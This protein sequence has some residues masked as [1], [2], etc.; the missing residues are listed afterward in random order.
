MLTLTKKYTFQELCEK[1]STFPV[2]TRFKNKGGFLIGVEFLKS[3]WHSYT[4]ALYWLE[5]GEPV[6]ITDH[7]SEDSFELVADYREISWQEALE[8]IKKA[9]DCVPAGDPELFYRH[10]NEIKSINVYDMFGEDLPIEDFIDLFNM[11]FYVA[12]K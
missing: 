9:I 2:G 7:I 6:F 11:E 3:S 8:R 10:H 12:N 1:L 4:K 5:S